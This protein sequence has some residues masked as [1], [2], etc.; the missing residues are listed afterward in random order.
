MAAIVLWLKLVS[1]AHCNA[2]LR[3]LYRQQALQQLYGD[4]STEQADGIG[5]ST[6]GS[7]DGAGAAAAGGA[8][9]DSQQQ[10]QHKGGAR[11][12]GGSL[13]S[14][15]TWDRP[16]WKLADLVSGVTYPQ[17]LTWVN[18]L[19]YSVVPTLTYQ[20][21]YPL[22]D[23][24][25]WKRLAQWVAL[26]LVRRLGEGAGGGQ[27][28]WALASWCAMDW[29]TPSKHVAYM[30]PRAAACLGSSNT[31]A[32]QPA[33]ARCRYLVRA[34]QRCLFHTPRPLFASG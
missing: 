13:L 6:P 33:A 29:N 28:A 26:L 19:W 3:D 10:Q 32:W 2:G 1:Y 9:A 24:I 30:L 21:S 5:S 20:C 16:T 17:N 22:R 7:I 25:R 11:S 12:A 27:V 15:P 8:A 14:Q 31:T 18:V 34:P 4:G 23:S